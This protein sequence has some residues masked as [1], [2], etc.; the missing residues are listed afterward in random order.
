MAESTTKKR[1]LG[2]RI[3]TELSEHYIL[4]NVKDRLAHYALLWVAAI[5]IA[6]LLSSLS[7]E[8]PVAS[9]ESL[10]AFSVAFL[11]I[12]VTTITF[13]IPTCMR[14]IFAAYEKY[15][16]TQINE[17][18]LERFPATLLALSAFTSLVVSLLHISGIVGVAIPI[19]CSF[20]FY[21][22]LFWTAVCII[23][24]FV[25]IEKLIH[26]VVKAPYAVLERL[27]EDIEVLDEISSKE[28]YAAYRQALTGM[29][30]IAA[31]TLSKSTGYDATIKSALS[32]FRKA[33]S[34]YMLPAGE[35]AP[36]RFRY[37]L[38][39]CR[40]AT[41]EVVRLFR[42]ACT[43]KNEFA[44]IGVM[45]TYCA[46][47]VDAVDSNCGIGYFTEM[48]AQLPRMQSYASASSVGEIEALAYSSWFFF[49]AHRASEDPSRSWHADY[50][51][52]VARELSSGLRK[53]T[54]EHSGEG[55]M[56]KFFRIAS[57]SEVEYDLDEITDEWKAVLDRSVFLYLEW[58]IDAEPADAEKYA[59]YLRK[60]SQVDSGVFRKVLCD[61]PERLH[62]A[63]DDHG[64]TTPLH[65]PADDETAR[66][67]ALSKEKTGMML[68]LDIN[69][70][71]AHAAALF[72]M[73][74]YAGVSAPAQADRAAKGA[75]P[76]IQQL[77]EDE[78]VESDTR[79]QEILECLVPGYEEKLVE[80]V[81]DPR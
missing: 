17:M 37:H 32:V 62:A 12:A 8:Q 56:S 38:N 20:A 57:N 48:L 2:R 33:H 19:D 41:H 3:A 31:T 74:E 21:I 65:A 59:G 26:F 71:D 70:D 22:A 47:V 30:D 4:T 63:L 15:Y 64:P 75:R 61:S 45:R 14:T 66:K 60:Y 77:S 43:G 35:V 7:F 6:W 73:L 5:L 23:Y 11:T 81:E 78:I 36:E 40:S 52:A 49:L 67:K 34:R 28:D 1:S 27:K 10:R 29:N 51:A 53:A 24:L 50:R 54:V 80:Y 55:V 44:A 9:Y 13:A 79:R 42:Q 72:V 46:M 16:S 18:L 39:A 68:S 69:D 76:A 25:A 58:L